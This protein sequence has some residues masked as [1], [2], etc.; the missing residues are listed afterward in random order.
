MHSPQ[1]KHVVVDGSGGVIPL[2]QHR[3]QLGREHAA[4]RDLQGLLR[5]SGCRT[6]SQPKAVLRGSRRPSQAS[7]P[8][9]AR[10]HLRHR[11]RG[12]LDE[13]A[14]SLGITGP[15]SQRS[16]RPEAKH[17]GTARAVQFDGSEADG[18]AQAGSAR[19]SFGGRGKTAKNVGI[20]EAKQRFLHKQRNL[21]AKAEARK[22]Q[23]L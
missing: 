13:E 14:G 11:S 9:P 12:D 1:R 19:D 20:F 8:S 15:Q 18:P 5:V 4:K 10:R 2:A 7:S 3:S 23:D 21:L 16:V 17:E 6:S 22:K